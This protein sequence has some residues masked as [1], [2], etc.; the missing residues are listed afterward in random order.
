LAAIGENGLRRTGALNAGL[1]ANDRIKYGISL[2]QMAVEDAQHPAQPAASLK[3]EGLAAGIDDDDLDAAV[4]GAREVDK[5]FRI[6]GAVR[7]LDADR[8]CYA[9]DG[10][11][12][13]AGGRRG[14][15]SACI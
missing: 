7:I 11:A 4:S 8:G 1:A 13:S 15:V 14:R 2:L 6:P 5:D 10:D 12:G 9:P 3:R